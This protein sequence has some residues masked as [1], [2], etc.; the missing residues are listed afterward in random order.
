MEMKMDPTRTFSNN[1]LEEAESIM[2]IIYEEKNLCGKY[3]ATRSMW[4]K[5]KKQEGAK[6]VAKREDQRK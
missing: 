5:D 6:Q 2:C 4:T 1:K 3:A